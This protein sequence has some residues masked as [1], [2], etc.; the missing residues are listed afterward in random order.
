M[1]LANGESSIRIGKDI[2]PHTTGVIYILEKFLPNVSIKV[3]PD[4]NDSLKSNFITIKG[5]NHENKL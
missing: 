4:E 3:T 2:T 1:A 5:I